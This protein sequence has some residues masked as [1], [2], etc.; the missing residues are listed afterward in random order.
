M[1]HKIEIAFHSSLGV[2]IEV[3]AASFDVDEKRWLLNVLHS[4]A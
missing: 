2:E 3:N 1:Y 4:F